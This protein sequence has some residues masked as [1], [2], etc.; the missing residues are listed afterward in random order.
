MNTFLYMMTGALV[1]ILFLGLIRQWFGPSKI[2]RI[3]SLQL[4]GTAGVA[5]LV[6]LAVIM[7]HSSLFNVALVLAL[8]SSITMIILVKLRR[9]L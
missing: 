6:L 3:L 8:L 4:F 1:A 5:I 2:D 9:H 7:G